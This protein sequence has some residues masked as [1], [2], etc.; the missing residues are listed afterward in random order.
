M[1]F[2]VEGGVEPMEARID[3]PSFVGV[4]EQLEVSRDELTKAKLSLNSRESTSEAMDE[5][6]K[7]AEELRKL[8]NNYKDLLK[9]DSWALFLASETFADFDKKMAASY[10]QGMYDSRKICPAK[11]AAYYD[12]VTEDNEPVSNKKKAEVSF[13]KVASSPTEHFSS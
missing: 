12:V 11:G 1:T 2:K 7:R 4:H 8:V 5:F 9:N 6:E 3:F 10:A 13:K